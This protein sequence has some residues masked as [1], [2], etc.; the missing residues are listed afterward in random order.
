MDNNQYNRETLTAGYWVLHNF[1]YGHVA[2]ARCNL[3]LVKSVSIHKAPSAEKINISL[4]LVAEQTVDANKIELILNDGETVTLSEY[5][6]YQCTRGLTRLV[7]CLI[8]A[9]FAPSLINDQGF[10]VRIDGV[11]NVINTQDA[12][13][14]IDNAIR[15]A[16]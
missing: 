5:I 14:I 13:N 10:I 11:D 4:D 15:H 6:D 9:T 1:H 8:P 7:R 3:K 2:E 16:H 12:A